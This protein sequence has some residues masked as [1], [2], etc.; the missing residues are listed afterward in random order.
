MVFPELCVRC[1]G[2][3]CEI[4]EGCMTNDNVYHRYKQGDQTRNIRGTE[5][6]EIS[7]LTELD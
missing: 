4:D 2:S 6:F 3:I 1:M 7:S 5:G